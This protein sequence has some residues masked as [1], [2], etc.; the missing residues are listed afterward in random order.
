M[1]AT[2]DSRAVLWAQQ[3]PEHLVGRQGRWA[4]TPCRMWAPELQWG[5]GASLRA[6]DRVDSV[7]SGPCR[8]F[9]GGTRGVA[10]TMGPVPPGNGIVVGKG[11]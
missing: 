11:L 10:S 1:E 5:M 6:Q 7:P 3:V 9:Q 4:G 2:R 8:N